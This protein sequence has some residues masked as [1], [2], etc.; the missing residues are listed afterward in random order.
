MYISVAETGKAYR[1]AGGAPIPVS[2]WANVGGPQPSTT[3]SQAQ[4]NTLPTYPADG[5]ALQGYNGGGVHRRRRRS[6]LRVLL[7]RRAEHRG[8]RA[9][10]T[11]T[12][13]RSRR[14]SSRVCKVAGVTPHKEAPVD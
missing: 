9:F 14:R 8:A 4:F 11:I 6:R 10:D 7:Q 3:I 12:T 2:N 13:A 1:I 5:T